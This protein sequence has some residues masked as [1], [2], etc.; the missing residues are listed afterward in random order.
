M[1]AVSAATVF[2]TFDPWPT[3]LIY[4]RDDSAPSPPCGGGG[5]GRETEDPIPFLME[6]RSQSRRRTR[7][8]RAQVVGSSV[9]ESFSA[10]HVFAVDEIIISSKCKLILMISGLDKT[11]HRSG[12]VGYIRDHQDLTFWQKEMG[13]WLLQLSEKYRKWLKNWPIPSGI[14][15]GT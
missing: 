15:T 3:P 7:W 10:W 9:L 13:W 1:I 5:G 12:L 6:T 4:I 8:S 2:S 14:L 11:D